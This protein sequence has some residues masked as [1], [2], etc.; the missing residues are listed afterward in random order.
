MT[1]TA[2]EWA[3]VV[4]SVLGCVSEITYICR[5]RGRH[6]TLLSQSVTAVDVVY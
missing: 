2:Q 5:V 6:K 3:T 4:L 1:L